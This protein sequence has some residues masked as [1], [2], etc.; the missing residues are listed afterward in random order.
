MAGY[1]VAVVEVREFFC[2]EMDCAFWSETGLVH[3]DGDIPVFSDAD[4]NAEIPVRDGFLFVRIC[5]LDAVPDR[6]SAGVLSIDLD[7]GQPGRI[8]RYPA[9]VCALDGQRI[10][11]SV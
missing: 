5:K 8:V 10:V 1:G 2:V 6:E 9:A 3:A 11:F 4:D 7:A